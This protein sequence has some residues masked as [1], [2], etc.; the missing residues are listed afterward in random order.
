[1]EWMSRQMNGECLSGLTQA[2][3]VSSWLMNV[4]NDDKAPCPPWDT[5]HGRQVPVRTGSSGH[6]HWLPSGLF[7]SISL[8]AGT[9]RSVFS[10]FPLWPSALPFQQG[11]RCGWRRKSREVSLTPDGPLKA[12]ESETMSHSPTECL[13]WQQDRQECGLSLIFETSEWLRVVVSQLA[14]QIPPVQVG[15]VQPP[16][17]CCSLVSCG[18]W[19]NL[20]CLVSSSQ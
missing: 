20:M 10:V 9:A 14:S 16:C 11:W 17:G 18:R 3:T 15:R 2:S 1:M 5:P 12:E 19:Y 6:L 13:D 8:P 7:P 4:V